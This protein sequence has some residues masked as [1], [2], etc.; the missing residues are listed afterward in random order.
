MNLPRSARVPDVLAEPFARAEEV[1]AEYFRARR[2]DPAHGTIEVLG[3]RYVILRAASLSV[4]FFRLVRDLY[5]PEREAEADL[6]S[7]NLLY[8]L[9]HAIGKSDARDLQAQMHLDDPML[10]LAAGP[11]HFAHSGWAFVEIVEATL[12]GPDSDFTLVY[13]HPFSFESDAWIRGGQRSDF[14]VCVMNA[15]YSSGWCAQTFGKELVSSEILCRARGDECCRFVMASPERIEAEI[16]RYVRRTGVASRAVGYQIP[17]FFSRKRVEEE[18][19]RSREELEQRVAER[20]REL[21]ETNQRLMREVAERTRVEQELRRTQKL[22]AV[23]RLAA[24]VAHDFN[25]IMAVILNRSA[26]AATRLEGDHP[27]RSDLDDIAQAAQR[28]ARLTRDLIAFSRGQVLSREPLDLNALVTDVLRLL[29]PLVGEQIELVARPGD[30]VGVVEADRAQLEQAITNLVMNARDAMPSG[31]TITIENGTAEVTA[32]GSLSPGR[33]ATLTV[34]DTGDGMD[35]ATLARIFEPFFTT[36]ER[37][38]GLGL[39]T[40]YGVAR[41]SGGRV[42]VESE[43]HRGSRFTLWLPRSVAIPRAAPVKLDDAV[44]ALRG[45]ERLM[46]VEDQEGVRLSLRAILSRFGYDVLEARDGATAL[47]LACAHS[48]I[49]LVITDVVMPRMGGRE[50]VEQ[51]SATRPELAVIFMSGYAE[52]LPRGGG[53][54]ARRAYLQKPFA[55]EELLRTIRELLDRPR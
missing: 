44:E 32:D 48:A 35:E 51:L 5:S 3:Q 33:Y 38:S 8:D 16:E 55:P 28:A 30:D 18:L 37:G 27:A 47:E 49:E 15:A 26:L 17:D 45:R 43:L 29:T 34:S 36:K 52:D 4:E 1:V 39:S 41:Q 25:N 11:A 46:L 53:A 54:K 13:D 14:P 7:R 6:F 22:E 21:Q 31:G 24:G 2:D 42:T 19:R 40:V 9:A 12:P 23:G 50:L 10:G 20:T